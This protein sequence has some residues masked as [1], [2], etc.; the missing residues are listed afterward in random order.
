[1]SW[2][3]LFSDKISW[4]RAETCWQNFLEQ[5]DQ[6]DC[7]ANKLNTTVFSGEYL[8]PSMGLPLTALHYTAYCYSFNDQLLILLVPLGEPR[9]FV[10]CV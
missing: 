8:Y 3:T 6:A 7:I 2:G 10:S 4:L 5:P 9:T 1:M